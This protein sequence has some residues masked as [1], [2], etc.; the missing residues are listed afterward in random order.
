MTFST[1]KTIDGVVQ[2]DFSV[3]VGEENV[4]CV[5][6]DKDLTGEHDEL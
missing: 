6:W 4:P 2:H 1:E 3:T 5:I